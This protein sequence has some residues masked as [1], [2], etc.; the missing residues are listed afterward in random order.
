MTPPLPPPT[1][2]RA[3]ATDVLLDP[4]DI[5][6]NAF[7]AAAEAV[8]AAGFDGVWTW[9][10]VAGQVH[11]AR[12]VLECWTVLSALAGRIPDIALGP[13]VLNVAN[14]DP[15]MLAVMASTLQAAAG[16]RLL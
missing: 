15:R 9:D 14:R 5:G 13:L 2:S 3:L 7:V 4:F 12:G 6:W 10:H 1:A 11:Q 8:H 16:G